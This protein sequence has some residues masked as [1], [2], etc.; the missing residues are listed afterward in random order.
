MRFMFVALTLLLL[1]AGSAHATLTAPIRGVIND[2]TPVREIGDCGRIVVDDASHF[3]PG[4]TV[5]IIQMQ[6]AQIVADQT[7]A[8]GSVADIGNAGNYEFN[9]VRSI[10]GDTVMLTY[11]LT[12]N[13]TI[14]GHVQ[15]VGVPRFIEAEVVDTLTCAPWNGE[16]GGVLVVFAS[17]YLRPIAPIDVRGK[18]FRGAVIQT[19]TYVPTYEGT[20]AGPVNYDRY[21]TKGEG[22]AGFGADAVMI[23]GRG[24]PANGGGGGGNHNAGGGGGGAI[25]G[26]GTGGRPFTDPRYSGNPDDAKGLGGHA[27]NGFPDRLF[28]GGGGGAG[29]DNNGVGTSGANGGGIVIIAAGSIDGGG[30]GIFVGG[31]DAANAQYDG[32][33]GA[34]GA[35]SI[36]INASDLGPNLVIDASGGRGGDAGTA[37]QTCGPGGGGGGGMIAF[38]GAAPSAIEAATKVAG[39]PNGMAPKVGAYGANPGTDGLVA[40]RVPF[41]IDTVPFGPTAI[42]A[43]DDIDLCEGDSVVLHAVGGATAHWSPAAGLSCTDC[44]DP[45][46]RPTVT[47]MYHVESAPGTLCRGEDSVTIHVSPKHRLD[48]RFGQARTAPG[49]ALILPILRSGDVSGLT[50]LDLSATY[51]AGSVRIDGLVQTVGHWTSTLGAHDPVTGTYAIRVVLDA[52]V[53]P[54]GVDTVAL[55][56]LTAYLGSNDTNFLPLAVTLAGAPPCMTLTTAPGSIVLDSIC[57]L[58]YRLIERIKGTYALDGNHPNPFNPSTE[59]DFALGLDGPTRLAVYDNAGRLVATVVD[60]WLAAGNYRVRWD[61]PTAPSGVYRYR[62]TSG[63]WTAEGTM[64]L[65]K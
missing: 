35:G 3:A 28:M 61:A 47:T 59:I 14:A 18:G 12:R 38:C 62:I 22:V 21:G 46:A 64:V 40:D 34:G 19:G 9:T 37:P 6:G 43:G 63:S 7:P 42:D 25:G 36:L 4:E 27:L 44:A 13:Y 26:G 41:P 29:H 50:S 48:V 11:Q 58:Q 65:S 24:A 52:A 31:G 60:A 16:T 39:G 33:G 54:V 10:V 23:G 30:G 15:L 32:G 49:R 51:D 55:I 2:Y 17:G 45:V 56:H 53:K 1:A 20:Y 8:Y 5:L 57:G